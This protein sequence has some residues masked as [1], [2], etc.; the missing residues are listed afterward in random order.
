MITIQQKLAIAEN[1]IKEV[2]LMRTIQIKYLT[3]ILEKDTVRSE[4]FLKQK[5]LAESKVDSL[6]K[7]Y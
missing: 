3:A 6:L 7:E 2:K 1:I 4:N 5:K